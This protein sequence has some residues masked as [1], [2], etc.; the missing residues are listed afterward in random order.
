VN[1]GASTIVGVGAIVGRVALG[2]GVTVGLCG[3]T[4]AVGT[5]VVFSPH[6]VVTGSIVSKINRVNVLS[7][8]VFPFYSARSKAPNE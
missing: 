8:I 2:L 5:G 1:P 6:V 4:T 3:V 7:F